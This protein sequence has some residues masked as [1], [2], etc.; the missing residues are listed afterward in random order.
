MTRLLL[1]GRPASLA[2]AATLLL[3]LAGADPVLAHGG[4]A[5]EPRVPGVLLEW[6][7]DPLPWATVTLAAG[8]YLW[9]IRHVASTGRRQHPRWRTTSFMA[10]L[11]AILLALVSPI[12]A[13][14]GALFSVHMLQH[15]LLELVAAPLLLLGAPATL[16]LR[17]ASPPVRRALLRVMHSRAVAVLSFPLLTWL[18]F[19]AVNWGWHF[20]SLYDQALENSALHY[21]QHATF[22]G[23]ALLF[24]WP[25]VGADPTR[26]RL[27]YPVRLFYL[28][29][30]MPQNSFLGVAL[31]SAPAV[32]YPHYLS[33]L[34][35]WGPTALADQSLGGILMWV[36]GDIVFLAAMAAV[37]AAWV[38]HEDRR[39]AR[40]DARLDAEARRA[41]AGR[42]AETG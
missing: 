11:A 13:Y 24:W 15:M 22:L 5:P 25:V 7:S 14:E 26:W 35:T 23:A 37:V 2:S 17:A 40:L 39:T 16:A 32:L 34:R 1:N 41:A 12:E 21:F 38:R 42:S 28:F 9:A 20:S 30:A 4:E 19:A 27:P 36:G 6:S 31:M 3:C 33:N 8:L 18:L 10:G 29:L